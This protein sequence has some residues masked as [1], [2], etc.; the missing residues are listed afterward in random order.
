MMMSLLLPDPPALLVGAIPT[1]PCSRGLGARQ[2]GQ[3]A[4]RGKWHH[5]FGRRKPK[6]WQT[7]P[8][9]PAWLMR[10]PGVPGPAPQ[11]TL[12][13]QPWETGEASSVEAVW[14]YSAPAPPPPC[15]AAPLTLGGCR[16]L[17]A[18]TLVVSGRPSLTLQRLSFIPDNTMLNFTPSFLSL[19]ATSIFP[20]SR[21]HG[22]S[23]KSN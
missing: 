16:G 17:G 13:H 14:C 3:C 7:V 19:C 11:H 10:E 18:V 6:R 15:V 21:F 12:R 20:A 4:P 5:V 1:P 22:R 23:L 2:P 8:P 9:P